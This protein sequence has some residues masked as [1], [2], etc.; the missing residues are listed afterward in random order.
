LHEG[1]VKDENKKTREKDTNVPSKNDRIKHNGPACSDDKANSEE[2]DHRSFEFE[3]DGVPALDRR[4]STEEVGKEG[5][6]LPSRSRE[7]GG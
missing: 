1:P 3:S 2:H 4:M 6:D 5:K 7:A